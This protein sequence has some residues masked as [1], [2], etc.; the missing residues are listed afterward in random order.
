MDPESKETLRLIF[1]GG[2]L[3]VGLL[4]LTVCSAWGLALTSAH[5]E[6]ITIADII[7]DQVMDSTG[8][9]WAVH[10]DNLFEK[11]EM[12]IGK[13]MRISWKWGLTPPRVGE[14]AVFEGWAE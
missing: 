13:K 7:G 9:I 4:G 6:E 10:F 8:N 5:H 2:L 12:A 1:F 14:P 11:R 3:G